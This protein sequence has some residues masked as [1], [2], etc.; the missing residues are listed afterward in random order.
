MGRSRLGCYRS[1]VQLHALNK[2]SRQRDNSNLYRKV[3]LRRRLCHGLHGAPTYLAGCGLGQM[4]RH[5]W[6]DLVGYTPGLD[7]NLTKVAEFRAHFPQVDARVA[8]FRR[9]EG[10]TAQYRFQ[11][12]DFDAF[13]NQYPGIRHF[14]ASNRWAS[15]L[16]LVV[17]DPGVLAFKLAGYVSPDLRR[18]PDMHRYLGPR[19]LDTYLR[20]FVWPWWVKTAAR[21]GIGIGRSISIGNKEKTVV[22]YGLE[23]CS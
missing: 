12:A 22:Y 21:H 18:W 4:Y 11:V 10:W 7:T 15:P 20:R 1:K 3:E 13:G 2:R 19:D 8:D 6:R 14:L 5:V 16:Y 17:A 23:L 9:F